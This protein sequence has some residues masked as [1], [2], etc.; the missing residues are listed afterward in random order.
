MTQLP[1]GPWPHFEDDDIAAVTDV[2]RSGK[3]NQWTGS[4]VSDFESAY[5]AHCGVAHAIAMANGTVTL[6]AALLALDV[7]PGDEVIVPSRTFMAT[8][9]C[10]VARGARPVCADVD[11][12]S[13]NVT[14]ATLEAMRSPRT[15]AVIVVHLGG[16]PCDMDSICD[17]AGV[18]GIAV[19]EDCAQAHGATYK[20]K[21]VGS[22][23]EFGS[24]SFC[25]DKIITTG[26][27]GG[28]LVMRDTNHW[29]RIWEYKDHGKS[30]DAVF[31]RQHPPGFRWV[32]E[33]FGTNWRMTSM[34]AALGLT[35]L[36]K[37]PQWTAQ[38]RAH[39][40]ELNRA[41]GT[42]PW[43]RRPELP[44]HIGHA[45]YKHYAYFDPAS[46]P[47][48]LTRDSLIERLG[49]SGVVCMSGSC[50]EIY[51]EK[52]FV[53]AGLAPARRHPVARELGETSLMFL[54]HPT[55]TRNQMEAVCAAISTCL[56]TLG[57]GS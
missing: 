26:G 37:L 44:P 38:R 1:L 34:Q 28:M 13:G 15:R 53:T 8:A 35:A 18:H 42:V 11:R 25:Q 29:R 7:G 43:I 47:R 30:Y 24:F 40:G 56:A 31:N 51:L 10:V 3:V 32:I 48:G 5:A 14:S 36:R 49:A 33:S 52:A 50:S 46:A 16:W 21:P 9:S 22:F 4:T 17:W 27:E 19:I 2:L 54:I 55:I 57:H 23:G 39:A 45:A 20:G 41:L 6:E 12:E